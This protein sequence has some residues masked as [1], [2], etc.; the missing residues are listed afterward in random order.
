MANSPSL[1]SL[2]IPKRSVMDAFNHSSWFNKEP[3]IGFGTGSRPPLNN[4][5]GGPGPGAYPIKT[6]LGI[7]IES[8]I[9][10]NP[11]YSLRG[12]TKFG[13][14]NEK[15]LSKTTANEP[16]YVFEYFKLL[17]V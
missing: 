7:V 17:S 14:P 11:Q 13:D 15:S 3:E 10:S 5:N 4:P 16:G 1:P 12:R 8:S 9:K 6:T 2:S